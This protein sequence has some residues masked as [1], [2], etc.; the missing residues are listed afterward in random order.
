MDT[1]D[2]T[3]KKVKFNEITQV[4]EIDRVEPE[5]DLKINNKKYYISPKS[6]NSEASPNLISHG[7]GQINNP[8]STSNSEASPNINSQAQINNPASNRDNFAYTYIKDLFKKF[9]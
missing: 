8:A 9:K 3:I 5:P 6:S 4:V 2:H 1:I 7:H